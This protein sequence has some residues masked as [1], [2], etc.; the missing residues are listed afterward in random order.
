MQELTTTTGL[1]VCVRECA[2]MIFLLLQ[3]GVKRLQIDIDG[4]SG[5]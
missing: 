3:T 1:S 4:E 2:R 5:D